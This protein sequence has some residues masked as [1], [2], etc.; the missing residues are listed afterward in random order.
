MPEL[1]T[2]IEVAIPLL[3]LGI[4]YGLN[5]YRKSQ[6][7][8]IAAGDDARLAALAAQAVLGA[9]EAA[10]RED[11]SNDDKREYAVATI[12]AGFPKIDPILINTAIDAALVLYDLGLAVKKRIDEESGYNTTEDKVNGG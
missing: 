4:G 10:A 1:E 11:W 3:L 6:A 7:G 9:E 2:I 12:I 5:L 8:K